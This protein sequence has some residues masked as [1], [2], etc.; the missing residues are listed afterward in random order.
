MPIRRSVDCTSSEIQR[1]TDYLENWTLTH[2]SSKEPPLSVEMHPQSL[3]MLLD[4]RV[5]RINLLKLLA[6][7]SFSAKESVNKTGLHLLPGITF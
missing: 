2:H 6:S 4:M 3:G 7:E 5:L 1:I